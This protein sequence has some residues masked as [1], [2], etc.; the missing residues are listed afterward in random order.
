VTADS[1]LTIGAFARRS[2]LSLKA[3]RLYD[4][5]GLLTPARIDED[6]GYRRYRE[7]QLLTARLIVM[8]RRLDMPL[9]DVARVVSAQER[10]GAA[11]D[12]LAAYWDGVERRVAGQRELVSQLRV[13]LA[14]SERPFGRFVVREREVADQVVLTVQRHVRLDGLPAFIG[15]TLGRLAQAAADYGGIAGDCFVIYHGE[16]N[17]DSDGPVE[18][19]VPV[20]AGWDPSAEVA[21]R[22]EPAHREAFVRLTKAEF[23]FP[24]ILSAFDAVAQWVEARGLT[25]AGSPREIYFADFVAATAGDEVCDVAYPFR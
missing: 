21:M 4:R 19:C 11:A 18:A 20:R 12:L 13:L 15:G 5:L 1:L 7:S 16:V 17:E 9:T 14:G 24:Q 3:L 8:L 2:R 23:A 10:D 22:R 6:S 25:C